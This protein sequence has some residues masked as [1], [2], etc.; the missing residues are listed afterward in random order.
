LDASVCQ[1]LE[2]HKKKILM[3]DIL[4]IV[5]IIIFF[6]FT[7]FQ[8]YCDVI[9]GQRLKYNINKMYIYIIYIAYNIWI[10]SKHKTVFFS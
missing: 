2:I 9:L 10:T 7:K 1:Y 8:V 3:S 5:I 4:Y 6:F